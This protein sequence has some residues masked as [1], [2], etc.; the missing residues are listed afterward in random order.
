MN[1]ISTP[2]KLLNAISL[3]KKAGKLAVGYQNVVYQIKKKRVRLVILAID[4]SERTQQ[5]ISQLQHQVSFPMIQVFTK[6]EL[7]RAVGGAN[8]TCLGIVDA[9][10][11][12]LILKLNR[13]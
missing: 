1:S 5:R 6:D 4:A 2:Q 10:L 13:G 8:R 12:S 11:A 7:S 3:A 9:N